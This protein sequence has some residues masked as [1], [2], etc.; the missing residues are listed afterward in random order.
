MAQVV[1]TRSIHTSRHVQPASRSGGRTSHLDRLKPSSLPKLF[2][3]KERTREMSSSRPSLVVA[4]ARPLS[5]PDSG[6]LPVS[7]DDVLKVLCF[8]RF[9]LLSFIFFFSLSI[10]SVE[11]CFVCHFSFKTT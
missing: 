11:V 2:Q 9:R 3:H 6:V 1:A 7:P 4:V 10:L 8:L 5:P